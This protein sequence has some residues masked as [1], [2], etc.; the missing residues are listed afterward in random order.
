MQSNGNVVE[1]NPIGVDQDVVEC[2]NFGQGEHKEAARFE[3]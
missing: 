2:E 1:G 3:Q